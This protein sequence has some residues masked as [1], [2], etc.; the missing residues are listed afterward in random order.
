MMTS[1]G[2]VYSISLFWKVNESFIKLITDFILGF[3]SYEVQ[4]RWVFQNKSNEEMSIH[5]EVVKDCR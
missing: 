2:L 4:L 5:N 3:L 1:Y